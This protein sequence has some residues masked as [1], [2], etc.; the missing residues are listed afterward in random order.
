[1]NE[2]LRRDAEKI[3]REAIA[4]VLP[5]RA[6][7]EALAKA[8]LTGRVVPVAVGKAAWR[9]A[10]AAKAELGPRLRRGVVITK[11]GHSGGPIEGFDI[12]EAGHPVPDE[13]TLTATR[14]AIDAVKGLSAGDTVLFLLSGGG[15]ALFESPL[16]PF[17]EYRD[18]CDQLLRCGAD[19]ISVNTIRKRL[20]AVKGGGFAALCRPASVV[21][22]VLSDV[23]GDRPDMIASG[24]VSEDLSTPVEALDVVRRYGLRL[25]GQALALLGRE[26]P[27]DLTNVTVE[28]T[29]SVRALCRAAARTC[30]ELG[31]AAE[32]MTDEM[33]CE[34]REAGALL[35][36]IARTRA[37]GETTGKKRALIFGGETVVHCTGRGKGGRC[38]E[39]ALAASRV[40][41]GVRGAAVFAFGSDGTDGP[42][43]AAGGYADGH[44]AAAIEQAGLSAADRLADN[45]AYT[46]LSACGGLIVT[47]PTGTNVN[48]CAVILTDPGTEHR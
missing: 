38:Q 36:A 3:V 34:A 4:A 6:V 16:I 8:R 43:D 1:M 20:S 17:D 22:V 33:A 15:S 45:D 2:T 27:R 30:E 29:G 13:R 39:L 25:S 37:V 31:Y 9:M 12:F 14:A 18:V 32:I 10:A 7:R 5:E 28:V 41:S 42:T 24:P 26:M 35:G 46:A 11:D 21:A 23:L 47:G 44:T 19:I 48:D 40:I